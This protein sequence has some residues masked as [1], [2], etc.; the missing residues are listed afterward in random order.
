MRAEIDCVW[1]VSGFRRPWEAAVV[2]NLAA[3]LK[4]R[5]FLTRSL[6]VYVS[7]GTANFHVDGVL[8]WNSLT[9]FERAALVL[10]RGR[11]WH[12]W[13]DAPLWWRW[14]RLRARTVHTSLDARPKWRGHPTRLFAEQARDGE[15]LIVPAFEAKVAWAD[16]GGGEEPQALLLAVEPSEVQREALAEMGIEIIPLNT[17]DVSALSL[18]KG[19]ALFIDDSPSNA[20][21]AAYLTLQGVPVAARDASLIR[22][23]LG[24]GGYTTPEGDGK[25][26][27]K[28]AVGEAMSEAGRSASASARRFLKTR[29]STAGESLET[30][31]RA[32]AGCPKKA[33]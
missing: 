16:G 26:D 11:L 28:K 22:A 20:L 25:E 24:P 3:A 32:V 30:L 21:L 15:S 13:G 12:L 31:Y 23:V 6:R 7:G 9:F 18:K 8:S 19:R 5:D 10:F 29:Y 27:W 1:Y 4:G 17:P 14:V 2:S 33:E